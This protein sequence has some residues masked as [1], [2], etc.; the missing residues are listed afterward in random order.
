MKNLILALLIALAFLGCE[1]GNSSTLAERRVKRV[2]ADIE[3]GKLAERTDKSIEKLV[4]F[5]AGQMYKKGFKKE[6]E[7]IRDEYDKQFAGY[8]TKMSRYSLFT[9]IGDHKPLS[10][11]L[12]T[13]YEKIESALGFTVCETLHLTDIKTLN[14]GLPIVFN[15][16]DF[17]MGAITDA[18]LVEYRRHFS[19]K[20]DGEKYHGVAPVVTYWTAELICTIATWGSGFL[21]CS[22]IAGGAEFIMQ[23]VAPK[24]SDKIYDM[25]CN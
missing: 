20:C 23:K 21:F 10:D 17:D 12:A 8:L 24:L 6:A 13:T 22:P 3:Q 15:P 19:G 2:V 7:Q 11:W 16:C 9:N 4:K 1:I 25:A 14:Y 18:R 5:A